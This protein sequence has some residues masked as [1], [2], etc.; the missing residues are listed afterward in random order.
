M[1]YKSTLEEARP[2]KASWWHPKIRDHITKKSGIIYRYKCDWVE[3]DEEYIEESASTFGER[4]KE[5]QAPLPNLWP[6]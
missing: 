6:Q 4:F 1:A 3:C 5:H 2:S